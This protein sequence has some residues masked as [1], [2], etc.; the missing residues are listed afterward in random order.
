MINVFIFRYADPETYDYYFADRPTQKSSLDC[1][2]KKIKLPLP[3]PELIT[4]LNNE[5]INLKE[6]IIESSKME[7]LHWKIKLLNL[8]IKLKS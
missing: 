1:P 4:D 2:Y 3:Y 8:K 7:M 6:V 5:I